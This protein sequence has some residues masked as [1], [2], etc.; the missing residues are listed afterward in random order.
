M[1]SDFLMDRFRYCVEAFPFKFELRLTI[2]LPFTLLLDEPLRLRANRLYS[3]LAETGAN[4]GILVERRG[5][6]MRVR[7]CM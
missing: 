7:A 4:V 3:K 5:C 6:W 1:Y 2:D